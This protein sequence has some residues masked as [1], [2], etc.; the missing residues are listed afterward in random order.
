MNEEICI[1]M[2]AE[3]INWNSSS[4]TPSKPTTSSGT[5]CASSSPALGRRHE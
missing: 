3:D 5:D 2:S 4:S 1:V